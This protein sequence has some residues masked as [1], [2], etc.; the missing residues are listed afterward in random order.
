MRRQALLGLLLWG[1]GLP[2]CY[3]YQPVTLEAVP[4]GATVRAVLSPSAS[5][6]LKERH[7]ISSGSHLEGTVLEDYGAAVALWVAS[8][9]ASPEFGSGTLYQQV[10]V[11][12][13]DILRVDLRELDRGKTAFLALGGAVAV[14]VA[15]RAALSGGTGESNSGGGGVPPE[16][17]GT[18][19]PIVIL[20]F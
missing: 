8:V 15:A 2:A 14:A 5:A 3:R 17:R 13:S 6:A 18:R 1:G 11:L 9:P 10:D 19:L 12:K 20:R 7:G 16:S 4:E